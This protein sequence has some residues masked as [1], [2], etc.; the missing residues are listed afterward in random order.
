MA[1]P[2][3]ALTMVAG[4]PALGAWG[5]VWGRGYIHFPECCLAPYVFNTVSYYHGKAGL[6]AEKDTFFFF[7]PHPLHAEVP[8]PEIEPVPQQQRCILNPL[9][10]QRTPGIHYLGR[11]NNTL[12]FSR[13][14]LR[15]PD[16]SFAHQHQTYSG[17]CGC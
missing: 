7:L 8:G 15:N 11:E 2:T 1:L 10:C 3:H 4:V 13:T 9:R 14:H 5:L 17:G 6:F 16:P 12:T